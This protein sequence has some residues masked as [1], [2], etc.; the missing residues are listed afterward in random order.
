MNAKQIPHVIPMQP[1]ITRTDRTSVHV[2]LDIAEMGL[3]AQVRINVIFL[4]F[5]CAGTMIKRIN[6]SSNIRFRCK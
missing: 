5:K 4:G 2:I 1:A 6:T 3:T